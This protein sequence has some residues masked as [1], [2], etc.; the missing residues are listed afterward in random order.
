MWIFR[1]L[2]DQ[3]DGARAVDN[4]LGPDYVTAVVTFNDRV[5]LGLRDALLQSGRRIPADLSLVG[6][7]DSRPARAAHIS[8]T[9]VAQPTEDIARLATQRAASRIGGTTKHD[10]S[11]TV[12]P[13]LAVRR[14][15]SAPAR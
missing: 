9:T 5:A 12:R 7:D 13:T 3:D 14:T 8:L 2:T 4:L 15:T 10:Q 11:L 6:Y 1:I